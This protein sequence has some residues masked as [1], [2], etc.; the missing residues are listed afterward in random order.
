MADDCTLCSV[1]CFWVQWAKFEEEIVSK[2]FA[3]HGLCFNVKM[4]VG[5]VGNDK[6]YP[7]I[8]VESMIKALDEKW[9]ALQ[10]NWFGSD[11]E[12]PGQLQ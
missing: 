12:Y 7:Y 11:H 2:T 3:K 8:K 1:I 6:S 9:K 10:T 4:S 5:H